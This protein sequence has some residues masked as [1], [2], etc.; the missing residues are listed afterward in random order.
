MVLHTSVG[1]DA[2]KTGLCN[3]WE[4]RQAEQRY[5]AVNQ[6]K[7]RDNGM[8]YHGFFVLLHLNLKQDFSCTDNF[9]EA[10]KL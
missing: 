2:R 9:I 7:V 6:N 10:E 3:H 1:S 4:C 8:P 5:K